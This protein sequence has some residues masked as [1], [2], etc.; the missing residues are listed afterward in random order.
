MGNL[1]RG[2][3]NGE[4]RG[5]AE[6]KVFD[7]AG[8]RRELADWFGEAGRDLPWRRTTDPYAVL[9]S[10][11][12]CQQTTVAAVVP[13]FERWMERWPRV[14]DL[15]AA[16]E[17][18]VLSTWEGL[19]Y[20]SRGRNLR[21]AAVAVMEEHGGAVPDNFA[22]LRSLPGVGEYTAN[23][24]LAF[25]F[26]RAAPVVDGNVARVL[27]RVLNYEG[28]VDSGEGKVW[29]RETA[30]AMQ[31]EGGRDYNSAVMELGALICRPRSPLCLTCPVET[32]CR[33]VEPETLPVKRARAKVTRVR[34]RRA[35]VRDAGG[36]WLERSVG[37][38]WRGMWMLPE[39][40]GE[41]EVL[42]A[43]D[44]PITRYLVRMEVVR[45]EVSEG[46]RRFSVDEAERVAVP[47]PHRRVIRRLLADGN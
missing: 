37:P 14:A 38:R 1:K 12:M 40:G 26:D 9:V 30:G 20:Y 4:A 2:T 10:V 39:A 32:Y 6:K 28:A 29:L 23:A 43:E 24:V 47:A 17:D 35:W 7:A 15:A 27:A 3:R 16:S 19:G 18:E 22:G 44:Y 42:L 36:I 5:A 45:G 46:L 13:Y 31:G 8:F 11:F 21:R 25:A 34:E 41:G 33:A